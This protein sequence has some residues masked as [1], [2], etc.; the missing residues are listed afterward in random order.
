MSIEHHP[1]ALRNR[2]FILQELQKRLPPLPSSSSSPESST[3]SFL[4]AASGTGAHLEHFAPALPH[5][6]F[7]PSE[8]V[9]LDEPNDPSTLGRIGLRD[10]LTVLQTLDTIGCNSFS[11]V[12]KAI[13]LDLSAETFPESISQPNSWDVV[14]LSNCLH[15]SPLACTHG[16]LKNAG[17]V[18][19]PEG[20][21][22]VYGPFKLHGLFT[23]DGGNEKF[24]ASLRERNSEWGYRDVD[25]IE[26]VGCLHGLV[27][28]ECIEMPA[29][30]FLLVLQKK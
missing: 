26:K 16:L 25:Y 20:L 2:I 23:G 1:S 4:E 15:I 9:V 3:I 7:Q 13:A 5:I 6:T 24:D 22:F 10:G 12:K 21:L 18:L 17:I 27:L 14:F 30:N 19:K 11:N 28:T 29:N 8:Y